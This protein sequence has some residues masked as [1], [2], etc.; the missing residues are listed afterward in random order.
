M[1]KLNYNMAAMLAYIALTVPVYTG[2]IDIDK[3]EATQEAPKSI[4]QKNVMMRLGVDLNKRTPT[5]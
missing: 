4:K 1:K 5:T 3:E 2:A